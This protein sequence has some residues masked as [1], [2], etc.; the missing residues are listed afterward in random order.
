VAIAKPPILVFP[1]VAKH[2]TNA[3]A[4]PDGNSTEGGHWHVKTLFLGFNDSLEIE[5][6]VAFSVEVHI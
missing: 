1:P 4:R 2:H 3:C 5:I 6:C